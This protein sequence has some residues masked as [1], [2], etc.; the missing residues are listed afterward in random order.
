[1][2]FYLPQYEKYVRPRADHHESWLTVSNADVLYRI[3]PKSDSK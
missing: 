3:L 2:E 1:M